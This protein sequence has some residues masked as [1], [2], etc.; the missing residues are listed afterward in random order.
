MI[1]VIGMGPG[2]YKYLTLDAIEKIKSSDKVIAFGRIARTAE[3]IKTPIIRVNR[4][5]EVIN[6]I[7]EGK[8]ISIL[9]SGDPCFYGIIEYLKAK[10]IKIDEIVPGLSSFQYMMS[11]LKKSWSNAKTLSFHGRMEDIDKVIN[12][13]LSI[14]LTDKNHNPDYISKLLFQRGC[15]GR[16]YIG[17]DLSYENEF[18]VEKNI[19]DDIEG[20]DAISVVVIENE[21]D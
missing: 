4:V 15:R 8:V 5:D 13:K 12:N 14:I 20:R 18:I 11:K 10:N 2:E 1:Y 9:A 16:M 7:D 17:Y 21:M 3:K 19:G 6:N